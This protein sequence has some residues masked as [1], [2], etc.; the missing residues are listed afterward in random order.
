[1]SSGGAEEAADRALSGVARKL[2]KTLSV[3]STVSGLV[4]EG[5]GPGES[6]SDVSR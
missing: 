4:T 1:M 3:A 5:E 2:E 6:Q